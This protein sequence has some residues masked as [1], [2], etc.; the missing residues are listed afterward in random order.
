MKT[1]YIIF[2]LVLFVIARR[3]QSQAAA[4]GTT[5]G[6]TN[7]TTLRRDM[8]EKYDLLMKRIEVLE[9]SAFA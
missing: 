2:F 5:T 3:K 1:Q 7:E 6:N 9:S 8:D 4:P